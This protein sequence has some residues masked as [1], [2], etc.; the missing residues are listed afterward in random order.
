VS[1]DESGTFHLVGDDAIDRFGLAM[2]VAR[3]FHLPS[4]LILQTEPPE[5]ELFP[6]AVPVDTSLDNRLTKKKLKLGPTSLDELLMALRRE[7]ET[8]TLSPITTHLPRA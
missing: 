7:L 4:D 5:S 8:G 1:L 2:M 6:A 3:I